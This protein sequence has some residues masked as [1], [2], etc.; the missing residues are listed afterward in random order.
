[1]EKP[2][3]K[4]ATAKREWYKEQKRK[5]LQREASVSTERSPEIVFSNVIPVPLPAT[6]TESG[7]ALLGALW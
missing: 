5:K 2:L 7:K 6:A 3:S 4:H 1:M